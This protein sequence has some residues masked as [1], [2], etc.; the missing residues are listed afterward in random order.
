MTRLQILVLVLL[1]AFML[2]GA[3]S[4]QKKD[5]APPSLPDGTRI[6]VLLRTTIDPNIAKPGMPIVLNVTQD[7]RAA[8][9]ALLIPKGARITGR[10]TVAVPWTKQSKESRVSL[11]AE[12]AEWKEGSVVLKA[13]IVGKLRVLNSALIP[14]GLSYAVSSIEILE[15]G[16]VPGPQNP[17]KD[18]AVDK[19]AKLRVAEDPHI[20]SEVFSTERTVQMDAG[21][22]FILRHSPNQ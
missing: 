17:Y 9:G 15:P 16:A 3:A 6:P 2:V 8:G 14:T 19:S 11:V 5:V 13:F 1:P 18:R 12:R 10:V 20:A 4:Q 21:S 7:V 22:T